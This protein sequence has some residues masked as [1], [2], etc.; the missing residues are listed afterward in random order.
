VIGTLAV[1]GWAVTFGTARRGLGGA[2]LFDAPLDSKGLKAKGP[3]EGR[4][5]SNVKYKI[6]RTQQQL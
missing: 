2:I 3:A 6:E 4:L 5:H 1:D